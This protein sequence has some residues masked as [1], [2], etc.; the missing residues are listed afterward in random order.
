MLLVELAFLMMLQNVLQDFLICQWRLC[1]QAVFH[2]SAVE[3][4]VLY[5]CDKAKEIINIHI[6]EAE[7]FRVKIKVQFI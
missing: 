2:D 7:N 3:S 6:K 4:E 1:I 5:A